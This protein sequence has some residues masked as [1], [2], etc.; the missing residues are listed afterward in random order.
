MEIGAIQ[1]H[2]DSSG[3]NRKFIWHACI[4]C[5]K[6]RW[7]RYEK[8]RA[9]SPRCQ[10]CANKMSMKVY[11]HKSRGPLNHKW[12]GGRYKDTNGYIVVWLDPTDFFHSMTFANRVR[13]H[14]LVM[15]KHLGRNL[16]TWEI[17][18]HKNGKKDDNRI[19]N[20]QLVSDE[21]HHQITLLENVIKGLKQENSKL[22]EKIQ[23]LE[24]YT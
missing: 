3:N 20:L 6:E 16:H 10:S 22:K 4:S 21:R 5:G 11:Q 24:G 9:V 7:M 1:A 2:K 17:V 18:H 19:E 15:A 13:E 23:K 14:R 8:G 12:K